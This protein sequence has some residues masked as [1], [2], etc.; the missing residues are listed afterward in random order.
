[1]NRCCIELLYQRWRARTERIV[2]KCDY[3]N[4]EWKSSITFERVCPRKLG[5]QLL[6]EFAGRSEE[7]LTD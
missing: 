3:T 7:M 5:F 1:M 4:V 6:R 2:M